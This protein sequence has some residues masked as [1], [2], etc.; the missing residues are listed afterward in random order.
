MCITYYGTKKNFP[1]FFQSFVDVIAQIYKSAT[2]DLSDLHNGSFSFWL[3]NAR[4]SVSVKL[5]LWKSFQYNIS[6][7]KLS[8]IRHFLFL[9]DIFCFRNTPLTKQKIYLRINIWKSQECFQNATIFKY[10]CQWS[11]KKL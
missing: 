6:C 5:G 10:E 4:M 9:P 8:L 3:N 11:K 7:S 2:R 1:Q